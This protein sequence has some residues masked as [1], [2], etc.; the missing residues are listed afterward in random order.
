MQ[1]SPLPFCV[2]LGKKWK[3]GKKG[4]RKKQKKNKNKTTMSHW[5]FK[6]QSSWLQLWEGLDVPL[7]TDPKKQNNEEP[8]LLNYCIS[9]NKSTL[10][11]NYNLLRS[12]CHKNNL[13]FIVYTKSKSLIPHPKSWYPCKIQEQHSHHKEGCKFI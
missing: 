5:S 9:S 7:Y 2:S 1:S 8:T 10:S 6:A 12:L 11:I 3:K 13:S 4:K